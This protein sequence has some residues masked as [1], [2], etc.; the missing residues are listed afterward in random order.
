MRRMVA[1]GVR[2][3]AVDRIQYTPSSIR[4]EHVTGADSYAMFS[5]IAIARPVSVPVYQP[6]GWQETKCLTLDS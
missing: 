6:S 5:L 1:C 2:S 3:A 4:E